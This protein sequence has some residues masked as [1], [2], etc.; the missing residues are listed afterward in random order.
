MACKT[1]VLMVIDGISRQLIEEA[2]C[3]IYTEPE[4]I[5]EIADGMLKY[6]KNPELMK[7]HGSNGYDFAKLHFDRSVLAE[8]YLNEISR[9]LNL[10]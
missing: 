4:N 10:V 7:E 3:G 9:H 5:R 6:K 2:D 1:P 8:K